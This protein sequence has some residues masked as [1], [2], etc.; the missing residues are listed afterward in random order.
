MIVQSSFLE[1]GRA[2]ACHSLITTYGTPYVVKPRRWV[3][4]YRAAAAVSLVYCLLC[5]APAGSKAFVDRL[6]SDES[7]CLLVCSA[8]VGQLLLL[9]L[10]RTV[11]NVPYMSLRCDV[12]Q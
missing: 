11:F 9:Q 10:Q 3:A 12:S 5:C 4:T 7:R 2:D 1:A 6:C 8:L